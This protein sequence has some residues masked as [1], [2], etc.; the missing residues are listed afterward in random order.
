RKFIEPK[1]NRYFYVEDPV[2]LLVTGVNETSTVKLPLHPDHIE[3][4]FREHVVKP[5]DSKVVLLIPKKDLGNIQTGGVVRLMGLFNVKII[6]IDENRAAAQYYSRSLQ[7][8]RALEAP[9]LHWVDSSSVEASVVMPD[10]SVSRG[11][12]E[13]DCLQLRVD[14]V[15][16]FERFGF[17][18]VDSVSPFIAYFAH[19]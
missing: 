15:I 7:E 9:F 6:R 5:D 2:E 17:V 16:Q 19:Q 11:K 8:A 12:A 1:A 3:R 14:D 4:G 18:R 13:P 10:A